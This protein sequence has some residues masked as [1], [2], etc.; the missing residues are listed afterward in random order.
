MLL[1]SEIEDSKREKKMIRLIPEFMSLTGLE[2]DVQDATRRQVL[3]L[4][5][6]KPDEKI[7][8]CSAL[9]D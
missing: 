6:K 9:V 4:C 5:N 7:K 3:K 2:D 1:V 8:G